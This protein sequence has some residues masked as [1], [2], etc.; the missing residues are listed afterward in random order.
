MQHVLLCSRIKG[1][2]QRSRLSTLTC[3]AAGLASGTDQ[4]D[5]LRQAL[6]PGQSPDASSAVLCDKHW[7]QFQVTN[8]DELGHIKRLGMAGR[9]APIYLMPY[10]CLIVCLA[11]WLSVCMCICRHVLT[12]SSF[13]LRQQA[14]QPACMM[15][16]CLCFNCCA[17]ALQLALTHSKRACGGSL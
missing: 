3:C 5:G 10:M 9:S 15:S 13:F 12:T 16:P 2:M 4:H 7:E 17:H 11:V 8:R 14:T 6:Q 1:K